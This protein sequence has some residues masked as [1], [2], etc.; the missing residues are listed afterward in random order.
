[1]L[2]GLGQG[3]ERTEIRGWVTLSFTPRRHTR[4]PGVTHRGADISEIEKQQVLVQL[5]KAARSEGGW[6]GG[7][8]GDRRSEVGSHSPSESAVTLACHASHPAPSNVSALRISGMSSCLYNFNL[9]NRT[10]PTH[11]QFNHH[12][13][14]HPSQREARDSCAVYFI[15][16]TKVQGVPKKMSFL[17]K[18]A[19]RND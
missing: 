9:D 6:R 10:R 17:G 7:Q 19:I 14:S 3:K 18:T 8:T 12:I 11:T 15:H 1:M 13:T 2:R 4:Q 16:V 5:I